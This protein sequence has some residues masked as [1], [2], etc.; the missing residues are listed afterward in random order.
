M[1]LS[2]VI[3]GLGSR[4]ER[5]GQPFQGVYRER[6]ETHMGREVNRSTVRVDPADITLATGDVVTVTMRE[7]GIVRRFKVA[8]L[9][10]HQGK[11]SLSEMR[12]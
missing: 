2:S 10:G 5:D 1:A 8:G 4:C 12:T 9:P 3:Q 7:T 11:V 6:V